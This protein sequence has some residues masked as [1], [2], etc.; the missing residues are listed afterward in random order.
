MLC[1]DPALQQY[2]AG[3]PGGDRNLD[4]QHLSC[5]TNNAPTWS[6]VCGTALNLARK[7]LQR[8]SMLK[9]D[10]SSTACE[11]TMLI[12]SISVTF[13]VTC[14]TVTSLISKSCQ[15]RWQGCQISCGKI[16][17]T[18]G[19]DDICVSYYTIRRGVAT[20]GISVYIPPPQKKIS[21]R[22]VH[23]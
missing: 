21:N 5:P 6:V 11:L 15:H 19:K 20:G 4:S 23:V 16:R 7:T 14:L 18:F 17:D 2:A 8:V 1:L 12:L 22:F 13:N 10:I 9:E 3:L